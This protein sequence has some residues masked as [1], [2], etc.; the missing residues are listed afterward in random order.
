MRRY[1]KDK[2][3]QLVMILIERLV[4]AKLGAPSGMSATSNGLPR[5]RLT[6]GVSIV[7]H[8]LQAA[9]KSFQR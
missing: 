9:G 7:R 3:N 2:V 6:R 1:P 8:L 5:E 4:V